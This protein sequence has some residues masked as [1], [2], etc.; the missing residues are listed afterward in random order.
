MSV[1]SLSAQIRIGMKAGLNISNQ[2][3]TVPEA[4][5]FVLSEFEFKTESLANFHIGANANWYINDF[6]IVQPNLLFSGKGIKYTNAGDG[7]RDEGKTTLYYLDIPVYLMFKQ[8]VGLAELFIGPG[9]YYSFGISGKDIYTT[10]SSN[11][12]SQTNEKDIKWGTNLSKTDYGLAFQ[13]GI[14]FSFNMQFSVFYQLGLKDIDKTVTG[15]PTK[16]HVFGVSIGYLFGGL[17]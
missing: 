16:N 4:G 13:G 5:G 15:Y 8:D 10:S 9:A 3:I 14:N 12:L 17:Y 1:I 7:Y 11:G 2:A 6:L